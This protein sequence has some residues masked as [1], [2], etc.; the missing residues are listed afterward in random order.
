MAERLCRACGNWHSL[1]E[2]WPASCLAHFRPVS[3]RSDLSRPMVIS[4]LREY[5]AVAIDKR[6]GK[7]PVIDG[8]RDHREFLR[9]N[10]F[11]EIGNEMPTPKKEVLTQADRVADI[12][13]AIGE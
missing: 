13:R 3:A 11:Q 7:R 6:T 8:R 12:K 5:R 1:D 9:A 10:N 2:T 4:D